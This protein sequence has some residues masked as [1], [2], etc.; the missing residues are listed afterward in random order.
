MEL[1]HADAGGNTNA[2]NCP[3]EFKDNS[4]L[5][6]TYGLGGGK[7]TRKIKNSPC[8]VFLKKK[9]KKNPNK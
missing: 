8:N 9:K 7:K 5:F 4:G 3:T 6:S 2:Q 1:L